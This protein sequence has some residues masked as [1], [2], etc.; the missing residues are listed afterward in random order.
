MLPHPEGYGGFTEIGGDKAPTSLLVVPEQASSCCIRAIWE[1][2][3]NVGVARG[4]RGFMAIG[5]ETLQ[6]RQRLGTH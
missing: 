4:L 2:F 5:R 3:L 6:F 1:R